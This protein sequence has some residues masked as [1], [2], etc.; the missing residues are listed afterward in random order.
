MPHVLDA[1]LAGNRLLAALAGAGVRS[2]PLSADGQI[3]P[4][5]GAPVA[6]NA[7]EPAD[8]LSDIATQLTF[9]LVLVVEH[10]V[11]PLNVVVRQFSGAALGR[12]IQLG[13]TS[14]A[15]TEPT[16]YRYCSEIK[17]GLSFGMS[18]PRT[19]GIK[20]PLLFLS[21]SGGLQPRRSIFTCGIGSLEDRRSGN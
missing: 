10:G 9:H 6:L 13:Q 2:R 8:V 21:V 17:V 12:N 16:P 3:L 15:T 4:V 18:T 1:L 14:T 7:A 5:A 20:N 11:D 19:R